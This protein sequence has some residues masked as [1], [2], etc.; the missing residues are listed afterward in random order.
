[1]SSARLAVMVVIGMVGCGEPAAPRPVEPVRVPAAPPPAPAPVVS[2]CPDLTLDSIAGLRVDLDEA[3]V[4][5]AVGAPAR[6]TQ[7][8]T[9]F[10]P[11]E[12]QSRWFSTATWP[13]HDLEVNWVQLD[14][15][16]APRK[17]YAVGIGAHSD[18]ATS[19]GIHIGSRRAEVEDAYRDAIATWG[20]SF[21]EA[22]A[23][24]F[25]SGPSGS[26]STIA[27]ASRDGTRIAFLT[28]AQDRV[29]EIVLTS[30]AILF[31]NQW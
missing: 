12:V 31:A 22:A 9:K 17:V 24:G 1:M 28:M 19:C 18:L 8:T 16:D 21:G 11:N 13:A 23:R 4:R 2:R 26:S 6:E 5:R 3:S 10:D 20:K 15:P 14:K 7:P 29:V 27:L 25:V 30:P